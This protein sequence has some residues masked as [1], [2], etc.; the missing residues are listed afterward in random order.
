MLSVNGQHMNYLIK[1]GGNY[2]LL[3]FVIMEFN[4]NTSK[5][6]L[7]LCYIMKDNVLQNLST[8]SL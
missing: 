4:Q 8:I 3:T 2:I 5:Q 6:L 7:S 1:T